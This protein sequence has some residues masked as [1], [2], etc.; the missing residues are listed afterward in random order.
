MQD[1]DVIETL[2]H[3]T[4]VAEALNAIAHGSVTS[5]VVQAWRIRNRIPG[6]WRPWVARLAAATIPG[7][8]T[9]EFL[10]SAKPR[11]YT[12]KRSAA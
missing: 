4:K 5:N 9:D 2:G 1:R 11:T 10:L 6:E 8:S 3:A 12:R 7:F